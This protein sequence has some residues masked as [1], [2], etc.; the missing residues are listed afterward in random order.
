MLAVAGSAPAKA[1]IKFSGKYVEGCNCAPPCPCELVGV[2]MGCEGVGGFEV[3]KGT[4][5]GKDISGIRFAYAV[6]PG[7][8]IKGYVD[9]PTAAKRNAGMELVKAAFKDWGKMLPPA[10][11]KVSITGSGGRYTLTVNGGS[12]MKLTTEPVLGLDKKSPITIS[13]INSVL[14]P[15]VKQ[16]R[17][18]K[19][20]Y[21]DDGKSFEIEGTN[22]YFNSSLSINGSL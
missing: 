11:A 8:W 17:V 10:A 3:T 13:N 5:N 6:V 19:C 12:I 4:F 7:E 14:H 20:S 2:R 16:G 18:V 15:I 21:S 1:S 9:A 22:A